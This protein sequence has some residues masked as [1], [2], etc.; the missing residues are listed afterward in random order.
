MMA[1][2]SDVVLFGENMPRK[3]YANYSQVNFLVFHNFYKLV[4]LVINWVIDPHCSDGL[5]NC[6]LKKGLDPLNPSSAGHFGGKR[7]FVVTRLVT[8]PDLL[9]SYAVLCISMF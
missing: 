3:F 7:E 5:S 9:K 6:Y 4:N 2:F 8:M 1:R